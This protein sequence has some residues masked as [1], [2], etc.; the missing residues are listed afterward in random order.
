[1]RAFGPY[2]DEVT[3]DFS[4]LRGRSLFLI[5]GPTGAGKTTILDAICFALFGKASGEDRSADAVRSDF[6]DASVRTE[7]ELDF[8]IGERL[9]RIHRAPEQDRPGG[10]TRRPAAATLW[11]L[12]SRGGGQEEVLASKSREAS[13]RIVELL[14][15]EAD[16]F[17]QVVL[18]PQGEFRRVLVSDSKEREKILE[19]LFGT[20]LYRRIE[21]ALRESG[22]RLRADIEKER[23]VLAAL[24][25]Q[26]GAESLDDLRARC[27]QA[28]QR[29][30]ELQDRETRA[31]AADA[32]ATRALEQARAAAA[33][34]EELGSARAAR[35]DLE[36][37]A[38]VHTGWRRELEAARRA[39]HVES[40]RTRLELANRHADA[41]AARL[42][43]AR[44]HAQR[45][46]DER[47][48]AQETL[49]R[50]TRRAGE[51]A[52]AAEQV[53][54][55]EQ[56]LAQSE[57][58]ADLTAAL[59]SAEVGFA[60]AD[61]AARR[62]EREIG[63]AQARC[64]VL[65]RELEG[66]RAVRD[67][68]ER[69]RVAAAEAAERVKKLQQLAEARSLLLKQTVAVGGAQARC[70]QSAKR[71]AD[72][73]AHERD[74]LAAWTAGQAAVLA[75]ML[76]PGQPCPVC[77]SGEH[78]HPAV[79]A[80][81]VPTSEEF[82]AARTAVEEARSEQHAAAAALSQAREEAGVLRERRDGLERE[83]GEWAEATLESV[84]AALEAA[85]RELVE[86]GKAD[87]RCRAI[88][89]EMRE[90]R[91]AIEEAQA[92]QASAQQAAANARIELEKIKTLLEELAREHGPVTDVDALTRQLAQARKR[93]DEMEAAFEAAKERQTRSEQALLSSQ[94]AV[95]DCEAEAEKSAEAARTATA[96]LDRALAAQGFD[97]AAQALAAR[98]SAAAMRE[99]DEAL[100][101]YDAAVHASA[102]RLARAEASAAG[103]AAPDLDAQTQQAAAARNALEQVVAERARMAEAARAHRQALA[104]LTAAHEK[105]VAL[106]AEYATVGRVSDV[107]S[108]RNPAGISLLRFVLGALLDD[109]LAAAS[110][111]L[112]RMSHQRFALTRSGERRDRRTSGGLDLEV[113]DSHTGTCRPVATLSGGESFLASLSLALGLADVVQAYSG[114]IHLE[115][116]FVDEGFGTLDPEALDQAMSA[117]EELQA[118][119]RLVGIISHVPELKERVQARLEVIPGPRGSTARFVG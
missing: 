28:E 21:E 59:R 38:D 75:R 115:T 80:G 31:R 60:D 48:D 32:V 40:D 43:A 45:S 44:E 18:I 12:S 68:L 41:A 13:D 63:F 69:R 111:R 8:A 34:L 51:R 119:G 114:G 106:E 88:E 42:A 89:K 29:M 85:R 109:V 72:A 92:D 86:A 24:V 64:E 10:K 56:A 9:Y 25:E 70:E 39:Q 116:M 62:S 74:V 117:L 73:V 108:G 26:S 103:I 47:R 96:D 81:A 30:S 53:R 90:R 4:E 5:H 82:D 52:A 50:E 33:A 91:E 55:L 23:R 54:Q 67:Q 94:R 36:R 11:R 98:R 83:L 20:E 87:V 71:L 79:A 104:A 46:V 57:R 107:A 101:R 37:Q 77:G 7:V 110:Q 97:S 100:S 2:A 27:E 17:R 61:G 15:F 1:M 19:T 22:S 113:F 35:A 112:R 95:A 3:L 118:G 93:R 14:G 84:A 105:V 99:L 16:Q 49:A 58:V 65:S 102:E 76:E 78:P 66:V 6:A